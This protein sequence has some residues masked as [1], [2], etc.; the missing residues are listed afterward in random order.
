MKP[1][2][3]TRVRT[4]DKI[5]HSN[6]NNTVGFKKI[7]FLTLSHYQILKIQDTFLMFRVIFMEDHIPERLDRSLLLGRQYTA[8]VFMVSG[9]P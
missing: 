7:F 4:F 6:L 8:V 9:L 5:P 3:K 1:N 2:T